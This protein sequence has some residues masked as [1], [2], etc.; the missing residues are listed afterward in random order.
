MVPDA[1]LNE[2]INSAYVHIFGR[3]RH[4]QARDR[5]RFNTVA[6]TNSYTL[7]G[8]YAV[9][10]EVWNKTS[11][12]KVE[13]IGFRRLVSAD[14]T[15]SSSTTRG[16]PL[17]YQ[18]WQNAIEL[19]PTPDAVYAMEVIY[20]SIPT[21]LSADG[22][23]PVINTMWHDGIVWLARWYYWDDIGDYP[24]A[25]NAFNSWKLWL[26]DKPAEVDEEMVD[27]EDEPVVVPELRAGVAPQDFDHGG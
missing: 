23:N 17:Q 13:K 25:Q 3:Y 27:T 5:S 10:Y 12:T 22:D 24:K 8:Q 6:G 2:H 26:S 18:T 4:K 19:F 14:V 20:K 16:T 11:N 7:S 21:A 1:T 15:V 9:V